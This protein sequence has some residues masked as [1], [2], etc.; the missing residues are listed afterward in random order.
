M[1]KVKMFFV[2]ASLLLVTAGVFAGKAKFITPA[3]NLFY[4]NSSVSQYYELDTNPTTSLLG[5]STGGNTATITTSAGAS[6]P[7][8]TN[9]TGSTYVRVNSIGF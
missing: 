5:Y 4:Y 6:Y 7:L 9:T 3:P 8:Y 2:A 1:N